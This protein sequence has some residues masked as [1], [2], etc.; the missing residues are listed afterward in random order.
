MGCISA[1]VL[2]FVWFNLNK[3]SGSEQKKCSEIHLKVITSLLLAF[4]AFM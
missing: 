3:A 4:S 1:Q 2:K